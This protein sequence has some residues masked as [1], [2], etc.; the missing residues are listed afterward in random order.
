MGAWTLTRTQTTPDQV[1]RVE[2]QIVAADAFWSQ[3]RPMSIDLTMG[4]RRWG[5]TGVQPDIDGQSLVAVC[6]GGPT[7]H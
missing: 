2:A 5:W 4:T 6:E 1:Y 3:Q 7:I